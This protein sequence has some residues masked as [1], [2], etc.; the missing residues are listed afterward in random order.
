MLDLDACVHLQEKEG[1]A[2][3]VGEKFDRAE[4][5]VTQ[6]PAERDRGI[7]HGGPQ[8]GVEPGR[9]CFLDQLLVAPL[10]RAVTVAE[11]DDPLAVAEQLDLHVAGPGQE[12]LQ[13]DPRVAERAAGLGDSLPGRRG[14]VGLLVDAPQAP[15]P[16]AARRLDQD[17]PAGLPRASLG[18]PGVTDLRAGQDRE[19]GRGRLR[20]GGQLVAGRLEMRRRWADEDQAGGVA[21]PRQARVLGHEAVAR[22]DGVRARGDGRGDHGVHVQVAGGSRRR[23]DTDGP[24]GQPCGQRVQV[25]VGHGQDGLDAEP[26]A[27]PHDAGGDLPAVRD[28]DPAQ[29]RCYP[30][31]ALT[32][33]R[34]ASCSANWPS[35]RQISLT[36][37][38]VPA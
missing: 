24:V 11:V 3:G 26:L 27:R 4:P 36:V 1:A 29:H 9:G 22:V 8:P 31:R 30:A 18:L 6:P 16:A 21:G 33:M 37:P 14:Q 28:E 32:R 38:A 12:P 19:A 2:I 20:A 34:T 17:R 25:R 35:S 7:V 13:V 15:A 10:E 23:A 5:A